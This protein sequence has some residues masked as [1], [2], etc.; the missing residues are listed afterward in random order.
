MLMSVVVE[1][2]PEV[3]INIEELHGIIEWAEIIHEKQVLLLLAIKK[4]K[5]FEEYDTHH[6]EKVVAQMCSR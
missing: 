5:D 6:V 1:K 2:Q 4:S 3:L